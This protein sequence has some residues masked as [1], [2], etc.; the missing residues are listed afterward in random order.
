MHCLTPNYL[1]IVLYVANV[2]FVTLFVTTCLLGLSKH[3]IYAIASVSCTNLLP[4]KQVMMI[5]GLLADSI[6]N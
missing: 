3:I 1:S 4:K 2:Y 5:V 6:M